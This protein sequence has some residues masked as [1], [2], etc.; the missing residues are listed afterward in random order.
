[1]SEEYQRLPDTA[2]DFEPEIAD[3]ENNHHVDSAVEFAAIER[4][5]DILAVKRSLLI[6]AMILLRSVNNPEFQQKQK[7][8]VE[9]LPHTYHSQGPRR[10][11]V[12]L[13]GGVTVTLNITYHHRQNDPAKQ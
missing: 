12:H 5:L 11:V 7:E 3:L 13:P 6:K 9:Q 1:M 4:R 10:N 2:R 8:F